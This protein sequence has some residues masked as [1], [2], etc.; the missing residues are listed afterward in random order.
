MCPNSPHL[1]MCKAVL[2][3]GDRLCFGGNEKRSLFPGCIKCTASTNTHRHRNHRLTLQT[4]SGCLLHDGQNKSSQIISLSHRLCG[5]GVLS[6]TSFGVLI[7]SYKV[8]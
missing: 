8:D 7:H 6:T 1:R 2:D 3:G 5:I 4:A